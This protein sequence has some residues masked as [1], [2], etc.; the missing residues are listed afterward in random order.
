[1]SSSPSKHS[2]ASL[3][4]FSSSPVEPLPPPPPLPPRPRRE[5]SVSGDAS[6]PRVNE[7]N[8]FISTI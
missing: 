7:L 6:S 5:G 3:A 4:V 1:M 2:L 8:A